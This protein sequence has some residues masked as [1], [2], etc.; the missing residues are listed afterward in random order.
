VTGVVVAAV[1]AVAIALAAGGT[2]HHLWQDFKRPHMPAGAATEGH[3][4]SISGSHR[5]QYWQAAVAAFDAHPWKGIGPGS[6][7]FYWAQHNT[8]SE[9]VVNAHS[10]YV[11]SLA[12]TGVIGLTLIGGFVVFV[13]VGGSVRALTAG[14]ARRRAIATAVAGFAGFAA[15]AAFDWVWQM[16]AIPLVALLVAAVAVSGLGDRER[17]GPGQR[18]VAIRAVSVI[19]ALVALWA[20][21][22]PLASTIEVRSSQ[23]AAAGGVYAAALRHADTA[24]RLEPSASIPRAQRALVLELL[25]HY[26]A[27]D[28]VM[29]QALA[30]G[31][32]DSS[33][34]AIAARIALESGHPRRALADWRHARSLDPTA[35]IFRQ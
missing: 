29:R 20:I 14:P 21:I 27:A 16:G 6:F 18:F 26:G 12:E 34:W 17:I 25:G 33:L 2:I 4:L 30:R 5:Y 35:A 1:A 24:R 32:T 8:L 13:V 28:Q 7:Q 10:L 9:F 23:S 19:T 11:E 31:P 22:V 3:L 15:A